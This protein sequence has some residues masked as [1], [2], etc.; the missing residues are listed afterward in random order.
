MAFLDNSGDIILDAV[1]TEAGRRRLAQGD[2]SFRIAKWAAADDEI[3]YAQ[4]DGNDVRGSA[5]FDI[6]IMQTPIFEATTSP[7]GLK[8]PLLSISN[9]NLLYLP[10]LK[11]DNTGRSTL[12]VIN[13]QE[14]YVCCVD[15]G[16][17]GVDSVFSNVGI[18][19]TNAYMNADGVAE[20]GIEGSGVLA[21]QGT[22]NSENLIQIDQGLDTTEID[23]SF[24]LE[25]SLLETA[26]TVQL[27]HRLLGIRHPTT[28]AKQIP[29]F[30]DDDNLATYY[31]AGSGLS[32]NTNLTSVATQGTSFITSIGPGDNSVIAGPRGS[33]ISFK[34]AAQQAVMNGTYLFTQL[35]NEM[36]HNARTFYYIDTT[37]RVQGVT[38]GYRID[39]P[40]R[41]VKFKSN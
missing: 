38:T 40:V 31:L 2:G 17:E 21:G 29:N 6:Q 34:L 23:P 7:H 15:Q 8:Y 1:L 25:A 28:W 13:G 26:V 41:C 3:N 11:I 22:K 18:A 27:D 24:G 16:T 32:V 35:G 19:N 37:I 14:T 30:V 12:A 4:Y 36:V 33:R 9:T 20:V 5:F 39:I 10:V